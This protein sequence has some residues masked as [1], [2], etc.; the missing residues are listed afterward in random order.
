M[1]ERSAT[2][3]LL[4]AVCMA[5]ALLLPRSAHAVR[6]AFVYIN[7]N[8]DQAAN[9]VSAVRTDND[10][11][12]R[13][14]PGSP[15]ATGGAGLVPATGA[16]FAHRIEVSRSR[17]LLFA[18]NDGS[19]SIAAFT[20][21]PLNGMLTPVPGSPFSVDGWASFSG[22]S[23]AISNDGRFLYASGTTVVSFF[24]EANGA[25]SA[26]G[27]EWVFGQ[28]VGGV[29][30]SGDNTRLYL[31]TPS[32]VFILN[33]GE[34]GLTADAPDFLSIGSTPTDLRLDTPGKRLWVGTKN[35]GILGY[36][37]STGAMN[38]VAG[39]PFFGNV[40]NLSGLSTDY[41][42]R[43]LFAYSNTGP[44]LL[45][46]HTNADGS[47]L[48]GP[49]SP[50]TPA[51]VS[52]SGA[53]APDG[54]MLFLSDALGQLDAWSTSD[55]GGLTHAA[56]YP[57]NVGAAHGFS[58]VA[59]FP[60]KNPTPAPAAPRGF[61]LALAVALALIGRRLTARRPSPTV[62]PQSDSGSGSRRISG[63]AFLVCGLVLVSVPRRVRLF[64][65]RLAG[66]AR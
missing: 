43:T 37:V 7:A 56:G 44:R 4:L 59:T 1:G 55:D 20:I 34:S 58:G 10:G 45:G 48:L 28:R 31:S 12:S 47:L 49:N 62:G 40:S 61:A 54:R 21:D 16:E 53:L 63:D 29:G 8:P 32:G 36:D 66:A 57:V 18:G 42:G 25:L 3:K 9:A 24:V 30:V 2:A 39:S 65:R 17:S 27:S 50:L 5:A 22:I 23:L 6:P 33:T 38:I 51:L 13:S 52:T 64:R 26:L 35:S 19:G 11:L 14:I 15:Y 60:D 41:Y 46:A